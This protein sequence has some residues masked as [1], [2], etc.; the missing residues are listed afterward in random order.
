MIGMDDCSEYLLSQFRNLN[1]GR[2]GTMIH[3][4]DRL[5]EKPSIYNPK[6]FKAFYVLGSKAKVIG[7]ALLFN[8]KNHWPIRT[9]RRAVQVF[10]HEEHRREGIGKALLEK[11]TAYCKQAR[12]KPI[13]YPWD[14]TSTKFYTNM[15]ESNITSSDME[16]EWDW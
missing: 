5:Q 8:Y 2:A 11:V 13:V 15:V 14:R 10:V 9:R 12:L 7:W 16:G 1:L 4:I 6:T 3:I